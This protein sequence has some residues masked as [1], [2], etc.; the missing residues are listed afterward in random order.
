MRRSSSSKITSEKD[1]SKQTVVELDIF[2]KFSNIL[3]RHMADNG[4]ILGRIRKL[5][6]EYF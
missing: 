6:V 1:V 3:E 2:L 5:F 4:C